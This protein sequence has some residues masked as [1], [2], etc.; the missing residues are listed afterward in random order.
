MVWDGPIT[1]EPFTPETIPW[2]RHKVNNAANPLHLEQRLAPDG[3]TVRYKVAWV[4]GANV[5]YDRAKLLSVGGFSFWERLPPQHA[6]EE[7]VVQFLLLNRYGGCGLLPSGTYHLELP[8][9]V[10][11]RARNATELYGELMEHQ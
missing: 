4:G 1:P 3:A 10:A 8:T 9:E 11:D 2:E 6:G 7:V 5:L